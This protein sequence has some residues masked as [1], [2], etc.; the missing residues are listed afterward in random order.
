MGDFR[1]LFPYIRSHLH[2]LAAALLLLSFSSILEALVVMLLG[3]IFNQLSATAGVVQPGDKFEFLQRLLGLGSDSLGRIA[4][5]LVAFAVMKGVCLYLAEYAMSYSGQQVVASLRKQLS[6]HL[7]D[8]SVAFFSSHPTGKLMARVITDTERLQQTVSKTLADFTRQ[9]LL[10]FVFLALV[11]YTDWK[12][13]LL[14]FLVFPVVLFTTV[15]LGRRMRQVSWRS[16]ENL[17]EISSKLQETITGQKIVKAFG[18]ETYEQER[19]NAST[20]RLVEANLK[21]ARI[22]A[23]GPPLIEVIG[24]ISFVPFLLYADFQMNSGFTVGAFV[25]FIAALFRLYEP[26]RKLSRMHL[27]FQQAFASAGRVFELL[28][29]RV[30]IR[31]APEAVEMGPLLHRIR[32]QNVHFAYG[33]SQFPAVLEGV[34]LSMERGEIVALVGPSGAGKSTL[35]G[36]LLRLYDVSSGSI[37]VDGRDIR[38]VTQASLRRQ[39]AI[40]T[41]E[42]LL[43]NDTARNNIA[44]GRADCSQEE[45]ESAARAAFCHDFISCLPHGY[46]TMIGERGQRL[47]GGQRQRIA[48]ARALLKRASILVLDEATSALDTESERLVQEALGN[49]MRRCTTLVIA[50]RLSTVRM[51]HRIVVMEGGRI[52]EIG[53]HNS[54]MRR[55]GL[56]RR[57][58]DLQFADAQLVQP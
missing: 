57:L 47:S 41:Q 39:I 8:Q 16:Q 12:L 14:S 46:Q 17:A 7:L 52:V 45:I 26:I 5:L 36:L 2:L 15:R 18:M 34:N 51:A 23:L 58:H 25:V 4:L 50:H 1:K 3:P 48:I 20:D 31:D 43:F 10:L 30:E 21:A 29:S 6:R 55:S 44:Y 11:F 42:T 27:F 40:V 22:G 54:L 35:A 9:V 19:F 32:F 13:A 37:L 53:D 56:Y 24:Y 28:E 33:P 49:L 38:Q